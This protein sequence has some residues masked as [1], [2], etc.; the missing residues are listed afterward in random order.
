[1]NKLNVTVF[2]LIVNAAETFRTRVN[3]ALLEYREEMDKARTYA[4]QFKDEENILS[5][6]RKLLTSTA[7]EKIR[8]AQRM[9]AA[10]LE[11]FTDQLQDQ[12]ENHVSEPIDAGFRD[13][14]LTIDQFGLKPSRTQIEALLKA[15]N[16]NAIGIEALSKVLTDVASPYRISFRSIEEYEGDL[17]KIRSLMVDPITYDIDDEKLHHE[18]VEVLSGLEKMFIGE[19]GKQYTTG[20]RWDSV[21]LLTARHAFDSAVEDVKKMQQS[22]VCD[23]SFQAAESQNAADN[24]KAELLASV[25]AAPEQ[26]EA[27]ETS[28][29]IDG[30]DNLKLAMEL[31]QAAAGK[32]AVS[33]PDQYMK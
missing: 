21:A 16:G 22:W 30:S 33:V 29:K 10:D 14:L 20:V 2:K 17:Q 25:G 19:D 23:V 27:Y 3:S 15:N 1:M 4:A 31:G 24:L 28:T 12:L 5:G 26:S 7:Q 9:L 18:A 8:K 32:N 6:Q 13:Q 11:R